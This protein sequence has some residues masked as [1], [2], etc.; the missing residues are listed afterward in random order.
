MDTREAEQQ[1]TT[2]TTHQ[3]GHGTEHTAAVEE[4]NG[5]PKRI[6]FGILGAIVA[7]LVI[8]FGVKYFLYASVH[9]GTDDARVDADPVAITTRSGALETRAETVACSPSLIV[10]P[11]RLASSSHQWIRR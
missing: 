7:V 3:N 8:I 10:T 1:K 4:R 5:P 9:E 2:A 11:S 6:I